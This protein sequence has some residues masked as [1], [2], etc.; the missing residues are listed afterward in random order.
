MRQF[1]RKHD[2]L[3]WYGKSDKTWKFNNEQIKIP[4]NKKTQDNFKEGLQGSGF[5][6]DEY[7]LKKGKVPEDW[8]EM[9]IAARFPNDGIRYCGYPTQKPEALLERIIKASSNE[10]RSCGRT[11]LWL[12]HTPDSS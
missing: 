7:N 4:H 3:Y 1:N 8:W 2:N 6:A 10:G 5:V 9:A 11:F 12:R